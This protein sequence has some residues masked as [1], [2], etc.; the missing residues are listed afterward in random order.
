MLWKAGGCNKAVGYLRLLLQGPHWVCANLCVN[1]HGWTSRPGLVS[2]PIFHSSLCALLSSFIVT[3][4]L[5]CQMLYNGNT[6][7]NEANTI[8]A[9]TEFIHSV[10][11][12]KIILIDQVAW[13]TDNHL[14][15]NTTM[16]ITYRDQHQ[17]LHKMLLTCTLVQ[18]S[19]YS[20]KY[21]CSNFIAQEK[22]TAKA[23]DLPS[24]HSKSVCKDKFAIFSFLLFPFRSVSCLPYMELQLVLHICQL[25]IRGFNQHRWKLFFLIPE[26]SQKPSFNIPCAGNYLHS[27][28]IVFIMICVALTLY[29]VLLSN[30]EMTESILQVICKYYAIVY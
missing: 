28:Y 1:L 12:V 5:L 18:S 24:S 16:A 22:G 20:Y 14:Y 30:P 4:G 29:Y 13:Q 9:H 15:R 17:A 10:L 19:K 8:A 2:T 27:I 21:D 3:E 23:N 11:C 25:P 26:N 6:V 7:L